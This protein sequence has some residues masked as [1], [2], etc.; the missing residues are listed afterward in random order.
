[1]NIPEHL[2]VD[3][4]CEILDELGT[5]EAEVIKCQLSKNHVRSFYHTSSQGDIGTIFRSEE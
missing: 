2:N 1:M 4:V 3:R 5:A